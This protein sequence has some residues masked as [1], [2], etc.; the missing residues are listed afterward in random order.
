MPEETIRPID[1]ISRRNKANKTSTREGTSFNDHIAP[2]K[3]IHTVD[4][5]LFSSTLFVYKLSKRRG[6][7]IITLDTT[8]KTLESIRLPST[9]VHLTSGHVFL[10]P[11]SL[12][13]RGGLAYS[14]GEES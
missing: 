12:Y 5:Y 1:Q 4:F 8:K 9:A 3:N 2:H 6:D 10:C 14:F 11:F 7:F 13:I